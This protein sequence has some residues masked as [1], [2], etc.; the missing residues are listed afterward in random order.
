MLLLCPFISEMAL[1]GK[2]R[3]K[4]YIEKRKAAEK[5]DEYKKKH[6]ETSNKSKQN[7]KATILAL[8]SA[9]KKQKLDEL[10]AASNR[11]VRK[12]RN[13]KKQRL[14]E[15]SATRKASPFRSGMA[16]AKATARAKRMMD[17]ALPQSPRK[18][19]R[20]SCQLYREECSGS[21]L[22]ASKQKKPASNAIS[23]DTIQLVKQFYERNDISRQAP[24]RKDCKTV[25]GDDGQKRKVQLR[26]LTI[27]LMETYA[28][29]G[30]EFP[31]AKVG[32]SK[33]AELRPKHVC[34]SSKLPHNMCLC[35]YHENFIFGVDALHKACASFPR[36]S[37]DFPETLLCDSAT[38]E[39]WLNECS[40]CQDAGGFK[41]NYTF[42]EASDESV[43][44]YMW[45]KGEDNRI[46]KVVEEGTIDELQVHICDMIPRFL[47]HCFVKRAQ[48]ASYNQDRESSLSD[49]H[50]PERA[51]MQVDFSENFTC[52][53]QDEI[54]SA[55][56]NQRQVTVFTAATWHSGEIHSS[57]IASDNLAHTK[58]TLVAYIDKL[59]EDLP[60]TVKVL[61]L[62]SDGPRSQ[63][64]NKFVAA[65]ISALEKKHGVVIKW[66]YFATSHG[67][68]PVD[69]IG[70]A[71]KRFV[72]NNVR[73]RKHIVK[74]AATFV[75]AATQMPK[76][77]VE[78]M[79]SADIKTRNDH[80]HL[81]DVFD[82]AEPIRNIAQ[83]HFIE[84]TGSK[85]VP[86]LLTTDAALTNDREEQMDVDM[87]SVDGGASNMVHDVHVVTEVH[88]QDSSEEIKVGDWFVVEYDGE[89]FPGEV[90]EIGEEDFRVSVM[91][92]AGKNWKWP[93]FKDDK[94]F[95]CRKQMIK[96]LEEPII[97]N[98]RGHFKF[99]TQF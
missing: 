8:P 56:W 31:E 20:V 51:V 7:R 75:A 67:K 62:W 45:K 54:Q 19:R 76:V 11:R 2:E 78:E 35:R 89:N 24:G 84:V 26:H 69:G 15:A 98:N 47:E 70:G 5:Y 65:S 37:H 57:V 28:L 90:K 13:L 93:G 59:M 91:H 79:T 95:Y 60:S 39:C 18:R 50:D 63:F 99:T 94:T 4:R 30:E 83:M 27:S 3:Q 97:A 80:L 64:K 68:G 12:C 38:R 23:D 72:W 55:H 6:R 73:L 61:S 43:T 49:T 25:R 87:E 82:K 96:K 17:K 42:D 86:F 53:H 33:F 41:K 52:V 16:F 29:F 36:Y 10:K 22:A 14:A 48:A 21:P 46:M 88:S 58:E 9:L 1:T 85:V 66:N 40:E 32:K 34:L 74:D 77:Q 71:T 81:D 92:S 44:W